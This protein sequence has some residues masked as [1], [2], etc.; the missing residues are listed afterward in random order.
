MTARQIR[1]AEALYRPDRE[2]LVDTEPWM[3]QSRCTETDPESFFP[4]KGGSTRA[5][6]AVCRKCEVRTECL[7]YALRNDERYGIWGGMSERERR[8]LAQERREPVADG[9][10]RCVKCEQ[11]K[12]LSAF[13]RNPK[14]KNGRTGKCASCRNTEGRRNDRMAV[15]A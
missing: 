9:H 14:T 10:Q 1:R 6:K 7:D 8:R 4:E 12:P 11:I 3:A 5:A 13:H 15:A 2:D